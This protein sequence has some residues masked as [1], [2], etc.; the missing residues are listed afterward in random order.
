MLLILGDDRFDFREF[1]DLVSQRLGIVSGQRLATAAAG[2]G[3]QRHH[4]IALFL[5]NEFPM[6]FGMSFLPATFFLFAL[7]RRA[8][9]FGMRMLGTGRQGRILRR[10]LLNLGLKF[11]VTFFVVIDKR[12]DKGTH[13]GRHFGSH[14]RWQMRSLIIRC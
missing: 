8:F 13:R 11:G 6:M 3:M 7:G 12:L 9:G 1:P 2:I 10:Q 14:I 4:V 5:G